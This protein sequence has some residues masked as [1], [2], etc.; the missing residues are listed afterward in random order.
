MRRNGEKPSD[1]NSHQNSESGPHY[2]SEDT[3]EDI[4]LRNELEEIFEKILSFPQKN[5]RD[6][7][8]EQGKRIDVII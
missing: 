7:T 5:Q 8:R 1:S 3:Q 4:H 6:D 2:F